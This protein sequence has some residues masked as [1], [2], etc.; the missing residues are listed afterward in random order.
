MPVNRQATWYLQPL[1]SRH[2]RYALPHATSLYKTEMH[3]EFLGI[4]S[5]LFPRLLLQTCSL[6]T[7]CTA[8]PS[9]ARHLPFSYISRCEKET[10]QYAV[11][12][13]F[14]IKKF[15]SVCSFLPSALSANQTFPSAKGSQP[16]ADCLSFRWTTHALNPRRSEVNDKS[17]QAVC[18]SG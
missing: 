16:T 6:A 13:G 10:T 1:S 12:C 4:S 14:Q 2:L 17:Y 3:T 9:N 11:G 5:V 7:L 8:S 18:I 15:L